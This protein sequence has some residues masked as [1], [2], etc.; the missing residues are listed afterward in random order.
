MDLFIEGFQS[1]LN[2]YG[3][4]LITFGVVM[5]I[6]FGAMPGL[7]ATMAV[8]LFLPVTYGLDPKMAMALLMALYIGGTSGG[9]IT[10]ILIKIPGTP[11]SVAT[12]WDGHPMAAKGQ[13]VKA[14]GTGVFYSFLGTMVSIVVLVTLAPP[15][16]K[17]ATRFSYYEYFSIAM[18]SLTMIA[19]LSSGRV[20]KGVFAGVLGFTFATFGIAPIDATRRFTFGSDSLLGGFDILP[21]LIG[22]FAISELLATAQKARLPDNMEITAPNMKGVRGFGFTLLEFKQQF[23]NFVRSAAIGVGIGILPGIGGGTSNILAYTVAKNQSKHP[24]KFGT[25]ILD[26]IVAPET[27]NNASIGGA[28]IPL[29]VLGIPGDT[30]TAML[31]GGF[32][33]HGINPGPLLFTKN[34]D[35]VYSIFAALCISA[36][37][38]LVY[39]FYGLKIFV[40]MLK[41]PKH[42]LMP[43]VFTLCVVGAYGISSRI[44]D[45]SAIVLFGFIGYM[46]TVFKIPAAPFI[47][48]FILGPMAEVNLRRGLMLSKAS[49]E[50]FLTRPVS[51]VFLTITVFCIIFAV[52]KE[53]KTNR[54]AHAAADA[55]AAKADAGNMDSTKE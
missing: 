25:G 29:L 12:C 35:L 5:G 33:M 40:Q 23:V 19:T 20:I 47:L 31:I 3:F 16:A 17:L 55:A 36:I 32:T 4:L 51:G 45:V 2:V 26:G 49:F 37:L 54:L 21:V 13:A 11:A 52:L 22:L 44:F 42:I 38:M 41:I 18:F 53:R 1:L 27:A 9:L 39:E 14:L 24:E 10:A 6:I 28:M 46:F 7:S 50:P 15:L 48:G 34:A 8:A 43:I 30:V